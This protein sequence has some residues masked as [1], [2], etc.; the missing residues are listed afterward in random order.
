M[1]MG[2]IILHIINQ[3][4]MIAKDEIVMLSL[5]TLMIISTITVFNNPHFLTII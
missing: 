5:N 2:L 4:C 1:N 3:S